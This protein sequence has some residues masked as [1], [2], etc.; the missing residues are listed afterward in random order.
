M[1]RGDRFPTFTCFD[2]LD[3]AELRGMSGPTSSMILMRKIK[4]AALGL[5]RSMGWFSASMSSSWRRNR[6]LILCFHGISRDDEHEWEPGLYI[7]PRQFERRLESLRKARCNV[8]PLGESIERLRAGTLS[9]RAVTI[10]FDDGFYDFAQLAWPLLRRFSFPATLYLTTYYSDHSDWPVFDPMVSYVLWKARG[11]TL[12]WPEV[13]GR[14]ILLKDAERKMAESAVGDYC[15][16]NVLS[17]E[18]KHEVL[19]ELCKRTGFDFDAAVHR[20]VMCLMSNEE[21]FQVASEGADIQLHT[22]RHR[23]FP[24]KESFWKDVG[25]NRARIEA[26][27]LRT[28]R[29][30][31]YP[32]GFSLASLPDWLNETGVVSATTCELG[33][34]TRKSNPYFLP[35][36]L[37]SATLTDIEFEGWLCGLAGLL[38]RRS[39]APS[40]TQLGQM[41]MPSGP[42]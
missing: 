6:L 5:G 31:C 8:L 14:K 32:G 39:V 30:F 20:R 11:L 1:W 42:T 24:H 21:V 15:L 25:E 28:P 41:D 13:V 35:R 18:Q 2:T 22:H 26:L 12:Y 23:V 10:T 17:G 19:Q 9:E 3:C 27:T 38:P 34:A 7:S 36:L 16:K 33:L 40:P 37:D 29:H 4:L